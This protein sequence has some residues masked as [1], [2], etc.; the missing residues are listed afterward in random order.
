M[1]MLDVALRGGDV[2]DGT[3]ARR[4]RA[5]VGISGGRV[6]AIGKDVGEA[7][8]IIDVSDR[9]VAPGFIDIH[10]HLDAQAFWDPTLSPSP[11]FGVTSVIGGNCG[12]SIAPLE[13]S[14]SDYLMR[15]LGR[16]E[17]MPIE[18]LEAGVPWDWNTSAE[19]FDRLENRLAINAGFMVGHS[20][21]RR[22]VMGGEANERAATSVEVAKMVE[23][24][25]AGL[26]AGGMGF[27]STR[28]HSH[29]D[30]NGVPVPSRFA[31]ASELIALASVCSEFEGTSV[32]CLPRI[33]VGQALDEEEISLLIAMSKGAQRP[34][35]WNLM[36]V[37]GSGRDRVEERF[38][39]GSRAL[40]EG[41]RIVMLV[42][43]QFETM[44][45]TFRSGFGLDV[46]PGWRMPMSLPDSEKKRLLSDPVERQRLLELSLSDKAWQR[47]AGWGNHV[48]VETFTDE[49]KRFEGR[50]VSDIAAELG[51][52]PFDALLDIVLADDL[53]TFFSMPGDEETVV[54]WAYWA[55]VCRD[56][57]AVIG[58][59]DAG[60]HLDM[61]ATQDYPANTI[62]NLVRKNNVME[63]EEAVH[64]LS[65]APA[66]LYGLRE[67][68]TLAE[69]L[70]ADIVVFDEDEIGATSWHTRF[71][72]PGGA[73]RLYTEAVGID[74]V[75]VNGAEIVDHG[76]FTENRP[77]QILRSG[78]DSKN[79][80]LN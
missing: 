74:H 12:F 62:L 6:V 15:M 19:Y 33:P 52:E 54:D 34:L 73:S 56:S 64:L 8:R 21:M 44:R 17:G 18:A 61:V 35:N 49:T 75:F 45:Y 72:L 66:S 25:R 79:P 43:P 65:Q 63:I 77:G 32:E 57:R 22:V 67:R 47:M 36:R 10:T 26:R 68:G 37:S 55:Q 78:K 69:G 7:K 76:E 51:K 71:D 28:S 42:M 59:S 53:W 70:P 11:L 3:G 5:D 48:I 23:L 31:D 13:S 4:V 1:T 16:V 9:I 38:A 58:G 46:F 40:A 24:L 39:V 50:R 60:A 41:A 30:A 14:E 2:V 29:N 80:P 20:T 27:S